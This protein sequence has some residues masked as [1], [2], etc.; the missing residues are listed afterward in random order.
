MSAYISVNGVLLCWL[1]L[2]Y[3]WNACYTS[4]EVALVHSL[5][6]NCY[7]IHY[8]WIQLYCLWNGLEKKRS[9]RGWLKSTVQGKINR[10][11]IKHILGD[12]NSTA[13]ATEVQFPSLPRDNC[14]RSYHVSIS[15]VIQIQ[16]PTSSF[17]PIYLLS[18]SGE[19]RPSSFQLQSGH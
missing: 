1:K 4:V 17:P 16:Q 19:W 10:A 5:V 11:N 15:R 13:K 2:H 14:Y 7:H 18:D 3:Q 12:L 6:H 9:C 8:V